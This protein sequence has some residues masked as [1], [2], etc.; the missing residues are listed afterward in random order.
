MN[1]NRKGF[2]LME[3]LVV[4]VIVSVVGVS[5]SISFNN[6]NDSTAEIELE[7]KYMEI[8]RAATLYLDLHNSSLETFIENREMYM[9]LYVL[10]E[11]NYITNDLENPV[12]GDNI[13]VDYYVKAYIPSDN[14]KVDTCILEINSNGIETC[15]ANSNGKKCGSCDL[16]ISNI[17]PQCK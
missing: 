3:L 13:S 16:R 5:A 4:I 15:L 2:T 9:K 17:N 10:K 6:I 14:S 11:Q 12:T 8:Q 7:N 1:N